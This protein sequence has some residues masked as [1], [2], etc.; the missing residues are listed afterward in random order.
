MPPKTIYKNITITLKEEESE[1]LLDLLEPKA[2][3]ILR[4]ILGPNAIGMNIH[5]R[6]SKLIRTRELKISKHESEVKQEFRRKNKKSNP[7]I[8]TTSK[9]PLSKLKT[10]DIIRAIQ[11]QVDESG[12]DL[13][14]DKF[15]AHWREE[16]TAA[17]HSGDIK[18]LI[19]AK[20]NF[21]KLAEENRSTKK[22]KTT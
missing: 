11:D 1:F 2:Y 22:A 13:Q 5:A 18:E 12:I 19:K 9:I 17:Y 21:F 7:V 4:G 14:E 15:L 20:D 6:L 10:K 3:E 8:D 16:W